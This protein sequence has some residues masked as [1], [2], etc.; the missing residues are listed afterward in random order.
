M[1]LLTV[2]VVLAVVATAGALASGIVSMA[3]GGEYD[4]RHS[5]QFMFARVGLQG[6]TLVLLLLAL[7]ISSL[8]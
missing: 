3:H 1:T 4:R 7:F 8:R 6:L 2:V 5:G